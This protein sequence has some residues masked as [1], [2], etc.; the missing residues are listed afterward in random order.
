MQLEKIFFFLEKLAGLPVFTPKEL[1]PDQISRWRHLNQVAIV[2]KAIEIIEQNEIV[3]RPVPLKLLTTLMEHSSYENNKKM[4]AKWAILLVNAASKR[5]EFCSHQI[6]VDLLNQLSLSEVELLDYLY[7]QSV[8]GATIREIA[9]SRTLLLK[10]CSQE[11]RLSYEDSLCVIEN[12]VRNRIL[13]PNPNQSQKIELKLTTL[14]ALF[15]REC[16][17]V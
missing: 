10:L 5:N 7:Q 6:F 2:R 14:G 11:L 16:T 1:I 15:M 3:L 9:F 17:Q 8:D 13:E 12:L 4:Q